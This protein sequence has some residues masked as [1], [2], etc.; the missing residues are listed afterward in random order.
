M[1]FPSP[2]TIGPASAK[3]LAPACT[4]FPGP[5]VTSPFIMLPS[6]IVVPA[7]IVGLKQNQIAVR[8]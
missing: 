4:T 1:T 7:A 8:C 3:I 6:C 2:I 5:I